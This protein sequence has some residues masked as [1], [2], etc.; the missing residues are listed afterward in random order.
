M[1]KPSHGRRADDGDAPPK[2]VSKGWGDDDGNLQ[3]D[4]TESGMS[5]HHQ[6]GS[7]PTSLPTIDAGVDEANLNQHPELEDMSKE[8]A[9]APTDYRASMPKLADLDHQGQT[10]FGHIHQ[11]S[12]DLDISCLTGV[13]CSQLDEEDVHWNPDAMLVQLTSELAEEQKKNDKEDTEVSNAL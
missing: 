13:L 2:S 3:L 5:G 11:A 12:G 10:K 6:D 8:V 4:A 7:D 1:S 9:A